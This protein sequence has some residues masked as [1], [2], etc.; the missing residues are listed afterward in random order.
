M[1]AP[2]PYDE[3]YEPTPEYEATF[4]LDRQLAAWRAETPP[5]R[6]AALNAEWSDNAANLEAVRVEHGTGSP[7]HRAAARAYGWGDGL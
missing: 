6:R 5:A 1:S 3:P 4:T 2:E 7:Q